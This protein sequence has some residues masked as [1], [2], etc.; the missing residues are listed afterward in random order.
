[1]M[2]RHFIT[3]EWEEVPDDLSGRYVV[4][5]GQVIKANSV[6]LREKSSRGAICEK[7]PKRVMSLG[8]HPDDA[9]DYQKELTS[10]GV[11]ATVGRDGHPVVASRSAFNELLKFESRARGENII[12]RDAGYGQFAGF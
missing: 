7:N 12:D 2:R 10:A 4:R 6:R 9:A 11:R 8:V 1:M 5:D 3:G